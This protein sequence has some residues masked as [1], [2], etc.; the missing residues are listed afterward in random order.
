MGADTYF[1]H[2][3]AAEET[4]LEIHFCLRSGVLRLK[5]FNCTWWLVQKNNSV[6]EWYNFPLWKH[7][8]LLFGSLVPFIDVCRTGKGAC[9]VA[10]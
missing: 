10:I 1:G 7:H 8:S 2:R 3:E 5:K 6:W 9:C 4:T